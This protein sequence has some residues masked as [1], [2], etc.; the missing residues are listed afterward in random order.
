MAY[1]REICERCKREFSPLTSA[2]G[3][4]AQVCSKCREDKKH[5][6]VINEPIKYVITA[7]ASIASIESIKTNDQH[8]AYRQFEK[9]DKR[10]NFR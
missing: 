6:I 3:E 7:R 1:V 10:K 2:R 8:G 9:R 4:A 5:L